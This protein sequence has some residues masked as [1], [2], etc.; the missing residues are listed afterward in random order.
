MTCEKIIL[1]FIILLTGDS[2]RWYLCCMRVSLLSKAT[3]MQLD[4]ILW[5][6]KIA[7]L[8]HS[9]THCQVP[10]VTRIWP[11]PSII[12][13]CFVAYPGIWVLFKLK[14]YLFFQVFIPCCKKWTEFGYILNSKP[15]I[16]LEFLFHIARSGHNSQ[17]FDLVFLFR[18]PDIK[19]LNKYL[20]ILEIWWKDA[21]ANALISIN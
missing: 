18:Y 11:H 6:C 1:S 5:L 2:K 15:I 14:E 17:R 4:P 10:A 7:K 8:Y 12:D 21:L 20:W 16:I 19:G 9:L 13:H 3:C